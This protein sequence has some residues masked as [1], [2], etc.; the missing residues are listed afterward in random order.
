MIRDTSNLDPGDRRGIAGADG[1]DPRDQRR[2]EPA[3]GGRAAERGGQPRAVG[4]VDRPGLAVVEPAARRSISSGSI[5]PGTASAARNRRLSRGSQPRGGRASAGTLGQ[6]A[7]R[8]GPPAV[9]R[10][11]RPT[12]AITASATRADRRPCAHNAPAA[13]PRTSRPATP[14]PP[15]TSTN[16]ARLPGAASSLTL[17]TTTISSDSHE[18]ASWLP[19]RAMTDMGTLGRDRDSSR[20]CRID[21]CIRGDT[22]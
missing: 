20:T 1:R 15:P 11:P 21:S 3:R 6:A 19:D 10:H 7:P 4:D 9:V 14:P 5:P 16:S 12:T 22:M 2:R 18:S 17:T 8:T 13:L